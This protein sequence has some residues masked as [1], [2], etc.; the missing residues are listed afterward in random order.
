M[1]DFRRMVL[2]IASLGAAV[3]G[4]SCSGGVPAEAGPSGE[5][6]VTA[7]ASPFSDTDSPPAIA[8]GI[9]PAGASGE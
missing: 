3:L 5:D 4:V 9:A 1:G 8:P 6:S 7:S 2:L